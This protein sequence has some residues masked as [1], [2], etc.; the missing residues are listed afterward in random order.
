MSIE[1]FVVVLVL[2][3]AVM[4]AAWNALLKMADDRVVTTTL[5]N[6]MCAAVGIALIPFFAA[7]APA[8]WPYLAASIVVHQFYFVFLVLAYR[9]GDLS[10]VYPIARGA[11]PLLVAALSGWIMDERLGL[12]QG[13]GVAVTSLGI[14]SLA[15]GAPGF[16]RPAN[17]VPLGFALG[18]GLTI[19]AYTFVDA[20]GV[21]ASGAPLGYVAWLFA[22]DGLCFLAWMVVRRRGALGPAIGRTWRTW[23]WG[24]ILTTGA[25]GI[26]LWCY[27]VGAVAPIA[28]LRE[29]S[30]IFAALIGTKL[31]G[32][33]FGQRRV[34]AAAIVAAGVIVMNVRF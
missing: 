8:S 16:L 18:T 1:P 3:A 9:A 34:L 30:V 33:P 21:R 28:A 19:A 26:V 11:G 4:H 10:H 22:L 20:L 25:Y 31:L 29:T 24:G 12:A 15:F 7:P 27:S 23:F 13:I 17:L 6:L 5:V 32:E 14:V 2:L